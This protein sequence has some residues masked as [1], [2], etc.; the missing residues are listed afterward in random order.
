MF[1]WDSY[2]FWFR[3]NYCKKE[4]W[5]WKVQLTER[6]SFL[7]GTQLT[8]SLGIP[9]DSI[10]LSQQWE[11][12]VCLSWTA[13]VMF[14]YTWLTYSSAVYLMSFCPYCLFQT[15]MKWELLLRQWLLC[16]G[17]PHQNRYSYVLNIWIGFLSIKYPPKITSVLFCL[18][19][20]LT[21]F[22]NLFDLCRSRLSH[23]SKFHSFVT[24]AWKPTSFSWFWSYHL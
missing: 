19:V 20:C 15:S 3:Y 18:F 4:W 11:A 22:Y 23:G 12:T 13:E 6:D 2:N 21:D 1:T 5:N 16:H 14:V 24:T 17:N 9:V 8:I 7:G 10:P